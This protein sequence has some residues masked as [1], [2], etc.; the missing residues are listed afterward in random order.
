VFRRILVP[1]DGSAGSLQA[2]RAA[3]Q[4]ARCL[5]DAEVTVLHVVQTLR[6]GE[7]VPAVFHATVEALGLPLASIRTD[8]QLGD[9]TEQILLAGI[10]TDLIVL[11]IRRGESLLPEPGSICERVLRSA[12]SPVLL[13]R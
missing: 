4:L 6:P 11:G 10:E 1:T 12:G 3:G 2:A 8:L 5:P 13:V 7:T 9:P